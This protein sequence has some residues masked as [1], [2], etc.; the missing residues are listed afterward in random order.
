MIYAFFTAGPTSWF[1][2]QHIKGD[3]AMQPARIYYEDNVSK[4]E[5]ARFQAQ[6]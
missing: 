3:M 6:D 4:D 2:W 5:V 1:L